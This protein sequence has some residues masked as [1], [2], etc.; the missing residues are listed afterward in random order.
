MSVVASFQ[1][2]AYQ[3]SKV[4]KQL[5]NMKILEFLLRQV[6]MTFEEFDYICHLYQPSQRA[7]IMQTYLNMTQS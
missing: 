7:E 2:P 1:E 3:K 6:N 5:L 4:E